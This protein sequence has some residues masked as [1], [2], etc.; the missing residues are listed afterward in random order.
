MLT[1]TAT[2]S[3]FTYYDLKHTNHFLKMLLPIS[4]ELSQLPTP[5]V[6]DY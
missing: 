6:I 3:S 2:Q 4:Q 1:K 5:K